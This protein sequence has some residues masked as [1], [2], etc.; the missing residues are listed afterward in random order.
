MVIELQHTK[1]PPRPAATVSIPL[2]GGFYSTYINEYLAMGMSRYDRNS[3]QN[4]FTDIGSNHRAVIK[5]SL[6]RCRDSKF[7]GISMTDDSVVQS[8]SIVTNKIR[9]CSRSRPNVARGPY[10][11]SENKSFRLRGS[12][13]PPSTQVCNLIFPMNLHQTQTCIN[14]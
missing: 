8:N 2:E 14:E 9:R 13:V 7:L 12:P 10:I 1:K 3:P 6:R 11:W 5:Y 4:K